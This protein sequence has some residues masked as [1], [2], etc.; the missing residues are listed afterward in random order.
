VVDGCV[1]AGIVIATEESSGV[2]FAMTSNED[3]PALARVLAAYLRASPLGCDTCEGIRAWW[4][5]S[6]VT[7]NL[8]E[9]QQV[10]DWMIAQGLMERLVAGD[11]RVR[12]RR[13]TTNSAIEERLRQ[14]EQS[15]SRTPGS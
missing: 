11:G 6:Q 10:L 12:Y 4:L 7:V 14:V 5:G 2:R 13:S 9:V 8:G 3:I 1:R 15:A